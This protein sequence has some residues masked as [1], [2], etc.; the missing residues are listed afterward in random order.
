MSY[1]RLFLLLALACP[2]AAAQDS[3][4]APAPAATKRVRNYWFQDRSHFPLLRAEPRGDQIKATVAGLI[5]P[6]QY[7]QTE[8]FS[9]LPGG[10]R[11]GMDL[12]VGR[13]VPVY[14]RDTG[15]RDEP[16]GPHDWGLE[17]VIPVSFH[18]LWDVTDR[19]FP[20]INNDY[21]FGVTGRFTR[22]ISLRSRR[23]SV[24]GWAREPAD[25]LLGVKL[26]VGH[27]SSHLGDEITVAAM[28]RRDPAFER[29]N[30]SFEFID[31]AVG[32]MRIR[33]LERSSGSGQPLFAL[34]RSSVRG[35]LVYRV[36]ILSGEQTFY[37]ADP[38]SVQRDVRLSRRR[39]EPY[40]QFE[41]E[42]PSR[43]LR[44]R[45]SFLS[46]DLRRKIV[47]DYHKAS[48]A[49]KEDTRWSVNALLG[50]RTRAKGAPLPGNVG[51]YLRGYYGVNPHGQFRS[52]PDFWM[53][54]LGILIDR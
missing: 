42:G 31:A 41:T 14:A 54:G 45:D 1:P 37:T 13:E 9:W 5:G 22:G 10:S 7:A 34:S 46:V 2:P 35:G 25:H 11:L 18:M 8:S 33:R 49:A 43:F 26:Q 29:M 36:S 21:R 15:L 39:A 52:D 20:I 44:R 3:L 47:Y 4:D 51:V 50:T 17:F 12:S 19:S 32:L 48:D 24:A 16:L 53:V 30:P 6:Y 23:E 40:V 27:E 38:L 28:A